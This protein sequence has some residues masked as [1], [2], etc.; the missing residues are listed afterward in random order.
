MVFIDQFSPPPLD[1][2]PSSTR[3]ESFQEKKNEINDRTAEIRRAQLCV[4]T[5]SG[6][7]SIEKWPGDYFRFGFC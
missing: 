1:R 7:T 5:A 3:H 4:Y 2:A 6:V